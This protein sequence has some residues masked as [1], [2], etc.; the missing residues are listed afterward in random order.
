MNLS[1]KDI[2]TAIESYEDEHGESG[3]YFWK[4]EADTVTGVVIPGL[5]RVRVIEEVG[6]DEGSGE[7]MYLIFSLQP[8]GT[9][10]AS[11]VRY[12]RKDGYYASFGDSNWDG[13]FFE[14]TPV[15]RTVTI[16]E[17]VRR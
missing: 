10:Y 3:W 2:E 12:F 13:G 16:F 9:E 11:A 14:V 8:E 1:V 7:E 15:Q 5:G 17:E 4:W 6:G